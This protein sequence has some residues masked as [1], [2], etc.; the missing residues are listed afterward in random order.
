MLQ[1]PK[2]TSY[3]NFPT[4]EDIEIENQRI[5]YIINRVHRPKK[6]HHRKMN[7]FFAPYR[8]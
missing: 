7:A 4:R 6:T 5:W 2:S 3:I 8:I 1:T